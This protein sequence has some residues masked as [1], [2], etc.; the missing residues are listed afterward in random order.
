V[1]QLLLLHGFTGS[2]QSWDLVV[3]EL[4]PGHELFRPWLLG[5]GPSPS[6]PAAP[7]EFIHGA[8]YW[9]EV[10]RLAEHVVSRGFERG[11]VAGYSLGGRLAL[12]LC[13]RYPE[14][15][16][17]AVLIGA[18][19]GLQHPA[20]RQARAREDEHWLELLE[21]EPFE[22]FVARWEQRPLFDSQRALEPQAVLLQQQIRRSHTPQGLALALRRLGLAAMPD[23]RPD[24]ASYPHPLTLAQGALD[25]KFVALGRQLLSLLPT[26]ELRL[27]DGCGHNLLLESPSLVATILAR[28]AAALARSRGT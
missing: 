25:E 22:H 16:R 11:V 13:T 4:G 2:P 15:F 24:L 9:A 12:G 20:E 7:A 19:P 18:H 27:V 23:L 6:L 5:H 8:T 3:R 14:R 17:S 26:A 1:T 28:H 21:H 10:A